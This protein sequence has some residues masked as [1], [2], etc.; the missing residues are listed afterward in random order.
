MCPGLSGG[1]VKKY[2]VRSIYVNRYTM[3]LCRLSGCFSRSHGTQNNKRSF[4]VF[5]RTVVT[6]IVGGC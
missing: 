3:V 1:V 4:V 2:I 5:R 6:M